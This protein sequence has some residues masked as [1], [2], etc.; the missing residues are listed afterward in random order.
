M[1]GRVESGKPC[2][3]LSKSTE[4][5]FS[6][7]LIY[8]LQVFGQEESLCWHRQTALRLPNSAIS[9]ISRTCGLWT[10]NGLKCLCKNT[11]S[12]VI[13]HL[14]FLVFFHASVVIGK[15]SYTNVGLKRM[16]ELCFWKIIGGIICTSTTL[17]PFP[18]AYE[19]VPLS[20]EKKKW[21]VNA[22]S[23]TTQHN[24]QLFDLG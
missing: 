9:D 14:G 7:Q 18:K 17:L 12:T 3:D 22:S 20:K 19:G 16:Q 8:P 4:R 21:F 1:N 13:Q 5:C 23:K 24:F 6:L 10:R 15:L 11:H 2:K